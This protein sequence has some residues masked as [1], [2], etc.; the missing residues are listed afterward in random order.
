MGEPAGP[1]LKKKGG[2]LGW[3]AAGGVG[4]KVIITALY[5]YIFISLYEYMIIFVYVYVC[6]CLYL[7]EKVVAS[8]VWSSYIKG[9]IHRTNLQDCREIAEDT[10]RTPKERDLARTLQLA[11]LLLSKEQFG[12]AQNILRIYLEEFEKTVASQDWCSYIK[13]Q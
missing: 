7:F 5:I 11:E 8:L 12:S 9:M 13:V 6:I 2:G 4:L 10:K 1:A 3:P